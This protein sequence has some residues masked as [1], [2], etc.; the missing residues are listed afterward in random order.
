MIGIGVDTGGTYT[1]AV[2]F[3]MK[4]RKVLAKCKRLTT[5]EDLSVGIGNALDAMPDDMLKRAEFIALSTT[6]ATNA[7]VEGKGG[8]A[9]LVLVG[10][11]EATLK[12]IDAQGNYGLSPNAVLPMSTE[13]SFDGTFVDQ[14]DWPQV[15]KDNEAF[16]ADAEALGVAE[17]NALRNGAAVENTCAEY[18]GE[19]LGVP[20]IKATA[21]ATELNVIERGATAL[22]N[23]RLL[24]VVAEFIVAIETALKQRGLDIPV[25]VVRSDGTLMSEEA[26]REWPVETILSGPAASVSGAGGLSKEKECMIVDMGGTTTDI[27]I[28]SDGNAV[29]TDG[30]RI[31]GWRTQIKGVY[32]DTI[33]LGGDSRVVLNNDGS[34]YLSPQRVLP[35]CIGATRWPQIK[36]RLANLVR[37]GYVP[38]GQQFEYFYLVRR[39]ENLSQF[40]EREIAA[41]D[42]LEDGP[43][44]VADSSIEW[45]N[46][47]L[48]RLER[49]GIVMRCGLTPTDA[50]HL[51]GLFTDYDAE[52]SELAAKCVILSR[53]RGAVAR[54]YMN[55]PDLCYSVEEIAN[56]IFDL[57]ESKLYR[58]IV[59]ICFER[60][61]RKL[62][63]GALTDEAIDAIAGQGWRS[64]TEGG[65]DAPFALKLN[66]TPSLVGVGAPTGIFLPRVAE[67][68]GA[69]CVIPENAEVA[70][71]IGAVL[72]DV[73]A[74]VESHV[75]ALR[76]DYGVVLG[77]VMRSVERQE[78][79]DSLDEALVAARAE[80]ERLARS[81]ARA[82]G[83]VG[84]LDVEVKQ[85]NDAAASPT[86]EMLI[87]QWNY[88][89]RATQRSDEGMSESA[90]SP[91]PP[92]AWEE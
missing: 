36:K 60:A 9:K 78:Q 5:K 4:T 33:G 73:S 54:L 72:S 21:I 1:D 79:F 58:Q 68:L 44:P 31:G 57:V 91:L 29:T 22:L 34:I 10:G 56:K 12:R 19:A 83:A 70:N 35:L 81:T 61:P 85:Q 76:G 41:I 43:Q 80:A 25:M 62:V 75:V 20:V 90:P 74:V 14:P 2:V 67:A 50:M 32:I 71:A 82:R 8:R 13:G 92:E 40:T 42:F 88:I 18:F 69:K 46:Y 55:D 3:D 89:A 15:H 59:R 48:D 39:P 66:I 38:R 87:M 6:L 37:D 63:S 52:A 65:P 53:N 77:Y 26:A 30:I 86:G 27:A 28:V 16:F 64:F 84:E 51:K 24:P 45:H 23:A 7:C 11:S 17:I 47:E 49:E